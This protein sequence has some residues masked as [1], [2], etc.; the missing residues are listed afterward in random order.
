MM[1][2]L[3]KTSNSIKHKSKEEIGNNSRCKSQKFLPSALSRKWMLIVPCL[4]SHSY[5]GPDEEG[6]SSASDQEEAGN[7]VQLGR[8]LVVATVAWPACHIT[9]VEHLWRAVPTSAPPLSPDS[10]FSQLLIFC[11]SR[12][13]Q[14]ARSTMFTFSGSYLTQSSSPSPRPFPTGFPGWPWCPQFWRQCP[15]ISLP[16]YLLE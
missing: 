4:G 2:Y 16:Q 12:S 7:R 5:M 15:G 6:V 11:G 9:G 14:N 10:R 3:F 1:S 13:N 8:L